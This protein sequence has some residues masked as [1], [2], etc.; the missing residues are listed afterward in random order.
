[1]TLTVYSR[2]VSGLRALIASR[3]ASMASYSR[4]QMPGQ[5]YS[6]VRISPTRQSNRE[7]YLPMTSPTPDAVRRV[8]AVQKTSGTAKTAIGGADSKV[9]F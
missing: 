2:S 1:M 5:R 6:P 8:G 4:P 9:S 3:T 7:V